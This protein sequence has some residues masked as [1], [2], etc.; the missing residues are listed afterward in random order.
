MILARQRVLQMCLLQ[1]CSRD[2][3]RECDR[4]PAKLEGDRRQRDRWV[5]SAID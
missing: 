4:L 2:R 1:S 3:G 5:A